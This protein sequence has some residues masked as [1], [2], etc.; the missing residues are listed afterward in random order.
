[1]IMIKKSPAAASVGRPIFHYPTVLALFALLSVAGCA[2]QVTRPSP[3]PAAVT[4]AEREASLSRMGAW[5]FDGRLAISQAGQGGNARVQWHQQGEDF[6]IRLS[7]PITGQSWRL[8]RQDGHA[9]LEGMEGGARQGDDAER[10]LL[11]ATGWQI[12]VGAMASWVRGARAASPSDLSYDPVGLPATLVQDGWAVEFR[13]WTADAVP[14]PQKIYARKAQ[15]SV[16]LVVERW[17]AE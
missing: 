2:Q 8:R 6:D 4:Q 5:F 17:G 1:M 7:A 9:T 16:R 14:L 3:A 13:G 15:A 12:P 10:L 11:E